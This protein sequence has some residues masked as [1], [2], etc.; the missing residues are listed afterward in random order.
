MATGFGLE[1]SVMKK[2][3]PN[4]WGSTNAPFSGKSLVTVS[5]CNKQGLKNNA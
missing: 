5:S 2:L 4:P 3:C 1:V